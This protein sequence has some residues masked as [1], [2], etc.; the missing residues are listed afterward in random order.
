MTVSD[1][2]TGAYV[3]IRLKANNPVD[4]LT[5]DDVKKLATEE[6]GGITTY[7]YNINGLYINNYSYSE[8]KD[9]TCNVKMTAYNEKAH[10][11]AVVSYDKNGN[12]HK[13]EVINP[14]DKLPENLW[15]GLYDSFDYVNYKLD[16][17]FGDTNYTDIGW[18][19]RTPITIEVPEGGYFE[20]TNK[21]FNEI[22]FMTNVIDLTIDLAFA[23][24]D[25]PEIGI[26]G[27]TVETVKQLFIKI[28]SKG[29]EKLCKK[30]IKEYSKGIGFE[31]IYDVILDVAELTKEYDV[32]FFK[33]ITENINYEEL[34]MDSVESA[35]LSVIAK[36]VKEV[37]DGFGYINTLIKCGDFFNSSLA[38]EVV[39]YTPAEEPY[40][41][42]SSG[43][44]VTSE[45]PLD[46]DY[47]LH[48]YIINEA[49]DVMADAKPTIEA[50]ASNYTMYDITLYK[51]SQAVQPNAKIKVMIPIPAGYNK[52]S[53][54]VYWYKADG[55][56]ESMNAK[57]QGDYAVFE[58]DHLSYYVLV[59]EQEIHSHSYEIA[60][61]VNSICTETGT[62]TYT[63]SCGDSYTE[64]VPAA[65]H[66]FA[67]GQS[68]CN[69]CDY[70]KADSCSCKCHKSGIA[71]I[72][73]KI[74]LIFQKIFKKNRICEGCGV[75]HY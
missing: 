25:L 73:F 54:Q 40:K 18:T 9:G 53:I 61:T 32:D 65:G 17:W 15:D 13:F 59:E 58:T 8:N 16:D 49:D 68:K 75:Y 24:N 2:V 5:M 29:I 31:N 34:I 56:L 36:P 51:S 57:V 11:G 37:L 48:S 1:N 44:K 38:S 30:I 69:N 64:T 47:V 22:V 60:S 46:P 12:I 50:L 23:V 41:R 20:I 4:V 43:V 28:G 3:T 14:K 70:D 72:I 62:I 6:Y 45:T 55:A 39:V 26:K 10:Y 19:Q 21:Y 7:F 63:C 52:N 35:V 27:A 42:E 33:I 71:K 74:I 66:S 67:D